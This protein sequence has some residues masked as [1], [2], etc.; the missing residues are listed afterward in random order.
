MSKTEKLQASIDALMPGCHLDPTLKLFLDVEPEL[1]Q[2]ARTSWL[3]KIAKAHKSRLKDVQA[4]VDRLRPK[5]EPT[6][7]IV[8]DQDATFEWAMKHDDFLVACVNARQVDAGN[9]V[10]GEGELSLADMA[11]AVKGKPHAASFERDKTFA[12]HVLVFRQRLWALTQGEGLHIQDRDNGWLYEEH[13]YKVMDKWRTVYR[14][15]CSPIIPGV[16]ADNAE[17]GAWVR[18]FLVR[19]PRKT[20]ERVVIP[21]HEL[22]T[23]GKWLSEFQ[24][25]GAVIANP[26][27]TLRILIGVGASRN[28]HVY[29]RCGWHGDVYVQPG[30]KILTPKAAGPCRDIVT[31]E[32]VVGYEPRGES[33]ESVNDNI[34]RYCEGN[35]AMVLATSAALAAMFLK[36]LNRPGGGFHFCGGPGTGKTLTLRVAAATTAN[37]GTPV[38]GGIIHSWRA[39]D[40]GIEGAAASQSDSVFLRDELHLGTSKA[41]ASVIYMLGDGEGKQTLTRDRKIR[42]T[43]KFRNVVLSSGEVTTQ[44]H[45]EEGDLAYRSGT[46]ARMCDIP[47]KPK[48]EG[49]VFVKLH[50]FRDGNAFAKHL[51]SVLGGNYGWHAEAL[52]QY[53]LDNRASVLA[54]L[55]ADC[56]RIYKDLTEARGISSTDDAAR[57][58]YRFADAAAVGELAIEAEILPWKKG[59]AIEG[60]TACYNTWL[61]ERGVG[62]LLATLGCEALEQF[63]TNRHDDFRDMEF[64]KKGLEPRISNAVGYRKAGEE[65]IQ[66][67]D[68]AYVDYYMSKKTF[69]AAIERPERKQAVLDHL[70]VEHD[71]LELVA[72]HGY[73][74]DSPKGTLSSKRCYRI[75][76]YVDVR[77]KRESVGLT[78]PS[79]RD[80]E[81]EGE[82]VTVH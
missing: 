55:K 26:A 25:A 44:Q 57:A 82:A 46:Q 45:I 53:Y 65:K 63:L 3:K 19:T 71:Y 77:V 39:S 75:R 1:A 21:A 73:Q 14:R 76:K 16:A 31:F 28:V 70:L 27:L 62:D 59:A 15:V 32:P 13:H 60:V 34:F 6:E 11:E 22:A 4:D 64:E 48:N 38:E 80:A 50:G 56:D 10:L 7:T 74:Y 35:P 40:N 33:L 30:G 68:F 78:Q 67:K 79:K 37:S 17:G 66:G 2:T 23:N 36:D 81:Y 51:E 61:D 69:M 9:A 58:T 24:K 54:K 5:E 49:G 47:I 29:D 18:E 12:A 72:R 43:F 20:I 8:A 41:V 52:T 42:P